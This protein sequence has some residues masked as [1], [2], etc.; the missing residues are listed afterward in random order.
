MQGTST[1]LSRPH[2]LVTQ[3][4]PVSIFLC[5]CRV[6]T[7]K[8]SELVEK[9][10][11]SL[12]QEEPTDLMEL[13]FDVLEE[14]YLG[15]N[16]TIQPRLFFL[17]SLHWVILALSVESNPAQGD[18]MPFE[19]IL[20][21][22]SNFRVCHGELERQDTP[23]I[24]RDKLT[25]SLS[26]GQSA[27]DIFKKIAI[28]LLGAYDSP[29]TLKRTVTLSIAHFER[30]LND[31]ELYAYGTIAHSDELI[32]PDWVAEAI[33][34]RAYDR[35][36]PSGIRYFVHSYSLVCGCSPVQ[37]AGNKEVTWPVNIFV[38]DY[39][40][41]GVRLA[42]ER[43]ALLELRSALQSV[44]NLTDLRHLRSDWVD[45]RRVLGVRWTAEGT[46]RTQI[47]Q[48]WRKVSG[49]EKFAEE[50]DQRFEQTVE[51]FEAQATDRL[52]QLLAWFQIVVTG[53][54]AGGLTAQILE[55]EGWRVSLPWSLGIGVLGALLSCFWLWN[56]LKRK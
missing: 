36:R 41:V 19:Q 37:K 33:H 22:N 4:K 42:L 5:P 17:P 44:E 14:K 28:Q 21:L 8:L 23:I 2:V 20:A 25:P 50:I 46:Q 51:F 34:E 39:V 18:S 53:L 10:K 12:T 49:M 32:N 55:G 40:R 11:D 54:A 1:P 24:G 26:G 7:N 45:Y 27:A 16:I 6:T 48:I 9:A 30:M 43:A 35:W 38:K 52:N 3:F 13:K 47:E 56:R 15:L 29:S 31:S